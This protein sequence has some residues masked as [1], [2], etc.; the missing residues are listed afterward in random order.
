[1]ALQ[2]QVNVSKTAHA[3]VEKFDWLGPAAGSS[4]MLG[5]TS[6]ST[7]ILQQNLDKYKKK[8]DQVKG[9]RARQRVPVKAWFV[10][11]Q[12]DVLKSSFM[13]GVEQRYSAITSKAEGD[14]TQL[15]R[16]VYED[17]VNTLQVID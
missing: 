4:A 14:E 8:L 11:P 10:Q 1:V 12:L 6:P 17:A 3:L 9:T 15:F 13:N 16:D 7:H 2:E 5:V